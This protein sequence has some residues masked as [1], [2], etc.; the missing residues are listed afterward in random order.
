MAVRNITVTRVETIEV[1]DEEISRI[2]L[3]H[4]GAVGEIEYDIS[5]HG[6]LMGAK[7]TSKTIENNS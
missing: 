2:L 3:D 4:F 6:D 1:T 5:S 7:I